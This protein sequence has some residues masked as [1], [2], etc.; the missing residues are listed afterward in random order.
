VTAG[1]VGP[2]GIGREEVAVRRV[3]DGIRP[4]DVGG[5]SL[6]AALGV[7]LMVGDVASDDPTTRIDSHSWWLVPVF[8][9]AVVPVLWW[10]RNL[11]AVLG[12]SV[13]VMAT[14]DLLFG[15]IVR[16]GAGL[17]LAFVLA[18]LVGIGY[19]RRRSLIGFGLVAALTAAVLAVDTSAGPGLIPLALLVAAIVWGIGR[20]AHSRSGLAEELRARSA[21]LSALRDRRAVLEVAG[22]RA[23]VSRQLQA[24]I[25][26]RLGRLEAT[27]EAASE[28]TSDA[29][30]PGLARAALVALEEDS[31]LALD[32]M[33][34]VVGVLRGGEVSLAPTPSVAQLDALLARL[35]RGRLTVR[36]DP[37]LLPASVELSAYRIVEHLVPVLTGDAAEPVAVLV[38]FD[39]QA[40]EIEVT[41]RVARAAE[42]RAAAGRA[43]E[44]A[45]LHAGSLEVKVARGQAVVVAHLPVANG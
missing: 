31:R 25:D 4:V 32:D 23:R 40:L 11:L 27:A 20:V 38:G 5:T 10:R 7:L 16:C 34:E 39:D 18:F 22:D 9:A 43:R 1:S 21:E 8:L 6:L 19:E 42:L 12:I 35:G 26:E 2:V 30:D 14:H 36:G 17:P 37:R 24:V 33:R 44:R 13:V 45:R 41:G 29:G 3:W 28:A 15:H